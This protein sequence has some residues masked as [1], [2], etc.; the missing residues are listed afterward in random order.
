M[1][2]DHF[3]KTLFILSGI[4][5]TFTLSAQSPKAEKRIYLVDLTGSMEGRGN[6]P[7]PNI[8]PTVKDNLVETI[9]NIE[10][11]R[12]D[13]LIVP[14]T[15]KIG[16]DIIS[17]SIREKES[18]LSSIRGLHTL[19]GDTNIA[20]AW[21]Y[22]VSQLDSTKVN[23][24]FLLTDGLHNNG[25][26]KEEL[27]NRLRSWG[28][29]SKDKIAYAFYVMLTPNA[30]ES[31]ICEIIDS[32]QNMWLIESMEINANLVR[33][34][35]SARKNVYTNHKASLSFVSNNKNA[36]LDNLGLKIELEENDFYSIANINKSPVGD[37]YSFEIIE[38]LPKL[39]MPL[40]TTLALCLSFDKKNNPFVFLTPDKVDFQII[41]QGP[42]TVSITVSNNKKGLS[43]L[44]L[45][46]LKY[47]EPFIG[48]FK[49]ARSFYE[50]F[51]LSK[52]DTAS[53]ISNLI[54]SWNEEAV[55]A[56]SSLKVLL[57]SDS[58]EYGDHIS[59]SN[60]NEDTFTVAKSNQD[61]LHLK[62]TVIP[63][64]SSTQF[65]GEIIA[66]TE[67]IDAINGEDLSNDESI[68]GHWRL[69][70]K[71]GWPFWI[72][73][74]WIILTL[75]IIALPALVII[76]AIK[77]MKFIII[78]LN[79]LISSW[80]SDV[81]GLFSGGKNNDIGK[82]ITK[83]QV[84]MD[85]IMPSSDNPSI[86]SWTGKRGDSSYVFNPDYRI[87][88]GSA[89]NNIRNQ[90]IREMGADL[91]D[92]KPAVRY[93]NGQPIFDRDYA[94][95]NKKPLECVFKDGI[96]EYLNHDEI[97]RKQG[98]NINRQKLHTKAFEKLAETY[99]KSVDEIMVFKGDGGAPVERLMSKW[100]CSEEEVWIRCNNPNHVQR[101][102]HEC[103]DEKTIQLVPRLYHNPCIKH[104]G[105]IE[106]VCRRV[107]EEV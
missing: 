24:L 25:P 46:K 101:V 55:R 29:S 77:L 35:I 87:P 8:L 67:K 59:V 95:K 72:W 52:P 70:Y 57:T 63:G 68:I 19:P 28:D 56:G 86:G 1:F 10:D 92:M 41:N 90:T 9:S 36:R 26:S 94:T 106:R 33:T 97:I 65:N 16:S 38:K 102:L 53:T 107:L 21:N 76:L 49:W 60:G 81:T 51:L 64:I 2:R 13:I 17:G 4:A 20:D 75:V 93:E 54:L 78:T 80:V 14:F 32:T 61:T 105:G 45:K 88:N 58:N 39:Q 91:G 22:G 47:K 71:R 96:G 85:A 7:T 31:E 103:I 27:Y 40:D 44:N 5:L 104:K 73:F 37:V 34:S 84:P 74:S 23:Y 69:Q 83:D 48:Y 30:K 100:N 62:T 79:K 11:L 66:L 15:N 99:G 43:D 82:G 98:R 6:V 18:I 50:P 3:L 89:Y 42:R 12:T